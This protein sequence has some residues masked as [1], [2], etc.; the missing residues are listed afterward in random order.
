MTYRYGQRVKQDKKSIK[1]YIVGGVASILVAGG[2]AF[3][4]FRSA[5][6]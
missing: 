2:M 1:K 4:A 6:R 5:W 3:P